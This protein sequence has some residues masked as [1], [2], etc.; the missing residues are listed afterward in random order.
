MT[1]FTPWSANFIYC[2]SENQI[3]RRQF[4]QDG[5]TVVTAY[6]NIGSFIKGKPDLVLTPD[7]YR[8]WM[9][10]FELVDNPVVAYF[11]DEGDLRHMAAIRRRRL[12]ENRTRLVLVRR[13]ELWAF[14]MVPRIDAIFSRPRYPRHVPNTVI[15]NYSAAMNAKYE[16][17]R[18]TTSENPFRTRYFC[19]LD[20]GLFRS[21]ADVNGWP[22]GGFLR[23]QP[24][25]LLLPPDF[26][27]DSVAYSEV[28]PRFRGFTAEE[29]VASNLH[30]V[31][32][33]F[34][35]AD[36]R[37]M[38][39]WTEE[40]MAGVERMMN[41]NWMATDQQVIY[42]IANSVDPPQRT[43]IQTFVGDGLM[44]D[45]WFHLGYLCREEGMKKAVAECRSLPHCF[46][47]RRRGWRN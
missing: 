22:V 23:R 34:F 26:R 18:R 1:I 37:V 32:G 11:D 5:I 7:T 28:M 21:L 40:F 25:E 8:N 46:E 38:Y 20:V 43:P 44:Y 29:L 42:Y 19:W 17:M 16:L 3:H 27:R 2:C 45:P 33:C 14:R 4:F 41:E 12:P 31:C 47:L 15:A 30:W 6:F 13:S 9:S 36:V 35:I 39:A 24:F 10:T